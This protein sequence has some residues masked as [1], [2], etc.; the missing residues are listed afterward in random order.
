MAITSLYFPLPIIFVAYHTAQLT[1]KAV[2]DLSS[3]LI[4]PSLLVAISFSL[5]NLSSIITGISYFS[6][7]KSGFQVAVLFCVFEAFASDSFMKSDMILSTQNSKSFFLNSA[8]TQSLTE[9]SSF[10]FVI[11]INSFKLKKLSFSLYIVYF[12]NLIFLFF[13]NK[14][15]ILC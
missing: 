9:S 12:C 10:Q 11:S 6:I 3:D 1:A 13:F 4:L 15:S 14:S 2:I 5:L 7:L 8:F